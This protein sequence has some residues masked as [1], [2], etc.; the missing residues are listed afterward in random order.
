M[1][2]WYNVMRLNAKA[3]I[4]R[5]EASKVGKHM[6]Q[7]NPTFEVTNP[8]T[9]EIIARLPIHSTDEVRAAVQRARAAQPAWEALG[10]EG[11]ARIMRKLR[12][13]AVAHK[14]QMIAT[15]VAES[16]KPRI[17]ALTEILYLA[18]VLTYYCANVKKFLA[19]EN[20][21]VH[22]V[23]TKRA[24]VTYHPFGVVGVISPWNFPL[25]LSASDTVAALMAG[26]AVVLK[27]SEVT[28]LTALLLRAMAKRAGVPEDVFQ[29]VTGL[30]DT[31]AALV[32]EANLIAFTGSVPTG[33]KVAERAART[34]T[35]VLL[36]LG[37]KDPMIVLQDAD[38]DRAVAGALYGGMMNAGQVCISVERVYVEAPIYDQF[39]QRL[40]DGVGKLRV[41]ADPDGRDNIDMGP[42]TFAR[43]L[44]IV[45]QQVADA[46]AKGATVMTGGHRR[47]GVGLFYE[48][49][50]LTDVTDDMLLMQ[51]E[52]FGPLLPVIKVADAD[53][54]IRRAND[55]RFGL[56]SSIWSRD[57]KRAEQ[58]ARR[59]EAG[60]TVINDVIINYI[61]PEVP[62]GGIKES[63]IG[64]RHG[65]RDSLRRFTRPQSILIDR[66]NLK[67][68]VTWFPY[69]PRVS[70]LLKTVMN[71]LYKR[72]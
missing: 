46:R 1:R 54:A 48:P 67:S 18:D 26:N 41:G 47:E 31:G 8:A 68:E 13:V 6:E 19:D 12:R 7:T 29:V 63:G 11:R 14:E 59:I 35:P 15:I 4:V 25:L 40:V 37:G 5:V 30:G 45:E 60:S 22:L 49:T 20:V 53:E 16:G 17:E 56:S 64:Y 69:T 2:V 34:L 50:I 71:L 9:C 57:K 58:L 62:F 21:A 39:V 72:K 24:L 3:R 44:Q 38:L 52:T 43:Q 32:D 27:P 66:L 10:S 51:E 23:K 70:R 42:L 55:S 65:G 33:K 36:E 28:P 61:V